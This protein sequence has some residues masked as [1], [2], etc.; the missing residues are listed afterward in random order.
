MTD[1]SLRFSPTLSFTPSARVVGKLSGAL[2]ND[3]F[4]SSDFSR[5]LVLVAAA[6]YGTNFACVKAID[7]TIP[8]GVAAAMRFGLAAV[9]TAPFLFGGGDTEENQV[10]TTSSSSLPLLLG[11]EIGVWNAVGYLSQAAGLEGVS[12]SKSAFICSMAVIVVPL[13]D[14]LFSGKT[15]SSRAMVGCA[16][17]ILG[18]GILEWEGG[19]SGMGHSLSLSA[20]EV[21]TYLQPFAFGVGFWRMERA[22]HMF[23]KE[24]L[25]LTAAQLLSVFL[26][27][28]MYMIFGSS[29]APPSLS[30][31]YSWLTDPAILASLAWTGVVTTAFT[32]W[33]ETLALKKL[34][35]AETT[36]LFS[37]EP[38]WGSLFSAAVFGEAFGMHSIVGSAV[39]LM[40][41][42]YSSGGISVLGGA[43][44]PGAVEE[45]EKEEGDDVSVEARDSAAWG[46][47]FLST[48]TGVIATGVVGV[49]EESI[50]SATSVAEEISGVM[51][52]LVESVMNIF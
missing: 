51:D 41:C 40:S 46:P 12:A 45:E 16:L 30:D 48:T 18:V 7:E 24:S 35:A 20:S 52:E 4:L 21:A 10:T 34:S 5:V 13:L 26:A 29:Q 39:I 17:A 1:G 2:S 47:S 38:V 50:E 49:L 8:I 43:G 28:T 31:V 9:V 37:T 3:F 32:V 6:L 25:K 27:S 14:F 19:G 42:I 44:K 22:M 23:P 36:L 33:L 15:L 11:L